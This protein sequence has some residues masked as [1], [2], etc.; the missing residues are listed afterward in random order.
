MKEII[1]L[2]NALTRKDVKYLKNEA[3]FILTTLI[4][5]VIEMET[6]AETD[7]AVIGKVWGAAASGDGPRGIQILG[8]VKAHAVTGNWD[9]HGELNCGGQCRHNGPYPVGSACS[10][11][12][13]NG[14]P[15]KEIK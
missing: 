9:T 4:T 1:K 2:W 8:N 13:L 5:T 3:L 7:E 11:E 10:G 6:L 12:M 15:S 14:V